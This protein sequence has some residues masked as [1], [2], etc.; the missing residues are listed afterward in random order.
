MLVAAGALV[1]TASPA[2]AA[3]PG[4]ELVNADSATNSDGWK[5]ITAS[6][7]VGKVLIGTGHRISGASGEAVVDD[8][9]PNG[10][11][12]TAPNAVTVE[13]YETDGFAGNWTLHAEAI[14][15]NVA[16]AVQVSAAA[17]TN[18]DDFHG[19]P[20]A[21]CPAGKTLTGTGYEMV[22]ALGE[23]IVDDLRPNGNP[24]TAPTSVTVGAY[25]AEP[26][27]GNWSLTAYGI[28]TN[29]L[30]GLVRLAAAGS[31]ED[32]VSQASTFCPSGVVTTGGGFE[33]NG[34]LGEAL[35]DDLNPSIGTN[36]VTA[37]EEDPIAGSWTVTAYGICATA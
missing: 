12:T 35:V 2:V 32:F 13:A 4:H 8:V 27:A 24:T 14:C 3:V 37:Y 6:C 16:G 19:T 26:I 29:P 21:T 30:P 31:D 23:A 20:A 15:A 18:S 36:R 7:P 28:C 11:P 25:E 1:V 33:I 9:R 34:A 17:P 10:N 22:G 5:T